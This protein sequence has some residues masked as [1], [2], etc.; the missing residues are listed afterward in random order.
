MEENIF[1]NYFCIFAKFLGEIIEVRIHAAPVFALARIHETFLCELSI[2]WFRARGYSEPQDGSGLNG[3]NGEGVF[4]FACQC[5][6][7]LCGQT[8]N[9]TV[10]QNRHP[11]PP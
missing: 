6:V 11:T 9:R 2:Y 3:G 4:G 7:S 8:G 10:T 1:E 5:I